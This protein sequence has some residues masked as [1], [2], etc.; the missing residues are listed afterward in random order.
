LAADMCHR[1]LGTYAGGGEPRVRDRGGHTGREHGT[2]LRTRTLARLSE[3]PR[4]ER[5]ERL[6]R[7]EVHDH[8]DIGAAEPRAMP[9]TRQVQ[10][11]RS[12]HAEMRPEQRALES[13]RDPA[14]DSQA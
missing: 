6:A 13:N 5:L 9:V 4:L 14:I 10:D 1:R 8:V 11:H 7:A 2:R 12:A 3:P